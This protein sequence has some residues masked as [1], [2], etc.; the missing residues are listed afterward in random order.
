MFTARCRDRIDV[1]HGLGT[2]TKEDEPSI[3]RCSQKGR[4]L[5]VLACNNLGIVSASI[6][7]IELGVERSKA[8]PRLVDQISIGKK[9][10]AC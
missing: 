9:G 5:I 10:T 7:K 8:V 4:V 1:G 2:R 6:S 3:F